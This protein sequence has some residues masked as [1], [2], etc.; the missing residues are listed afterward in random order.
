MSV[1]LHITREEIELAR[2]WLG[3]SISELQ[4]SGNMNMQFLSKQLIQGFMGSATGHRFPA[5]HEISL[6]HSGQSGL[7]LKLPTH[8][9]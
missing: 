9:R 3:L 1:A 7:G 4:E 5:G 8:L 6:R 2:P